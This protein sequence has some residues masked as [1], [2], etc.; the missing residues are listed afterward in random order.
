MPDRINH[1]SSLETLTFLFVIAVIFV[2]VAVFFAVKLA[3]Y[4]SMDTLSLSRNGF[5]WF[6]L[7]LFL[8]VTVVTLG[9]IIL[10]SLFKML[11]LKKGGSYVAEHLGGRRVTRLSADKDE[12]RLLNAVEEMAIA[13]GVPV[14]QVYLMAEETGINAFAAGYTPGTPPLPS[15]AAVFRP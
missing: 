12:K 7:Q 5:K 9:V 4:V 6:D 2:A 3:F 11:Q 14:P 13:S 10:G 1:G 8:L 15:R